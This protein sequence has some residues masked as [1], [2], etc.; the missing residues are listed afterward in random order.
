MSGL[1]K[2]FAAVVAIL[3][4][5]VCAPEGVSALSPRT[6]PALR[7]VVSELNRE[8]GSDT[9]VS[10]P[11][12]ASGPVVMQDEF[13]CI[14]HEFDVSFECRPDW[15]WLRMEDKIIVIISTDPTVTLTLAKDDERIVF[16]EQLTP[17]RLGAANKYRDDFQIEPVR[18]SGSPAVK[19]KA[20]ARNW[21]D[22]RLSE[23]YYLRAS[24]LH[25]VSFAVH[26]RDAWPQQQ[27]LIQSIIDSFHFSP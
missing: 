24:S 4:T 10:W 7:G 8:L 27:Y 15:K 20:Y 17:R 14:C 5:G 2:N 26:P 16:L 1:T 19:V 22:V 21:E 18:I 6:S 13:L 25:R 3:L 11:E 23:Y 9:R 12:E